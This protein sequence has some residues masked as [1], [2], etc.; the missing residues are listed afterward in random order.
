MYGLEDDGPV[1]ALGIEEAEIDEN[2]AWSGQ[3]NG[4]PLT[5]PICHAVSCT[6]GTALPL[7]QL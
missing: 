3:Q 7:V 5:N 1:Q 4:L 2:D 6:A